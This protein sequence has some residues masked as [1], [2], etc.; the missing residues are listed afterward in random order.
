MD[1][2]LVNTARFKK[3][4]LQELFG[5][6]CEEWQLT[7]N[8]IDDY[9]IDRDKRRCVGRLSATAVHS[10][11]TEDDLL[12]CLRRI[13]ECS[14]E[15]VL[16]SSRGKS[17][18]G[19][20]AARDT[21]RTSGLSAVFPDETIY[22]CEDYSTKVRLVAQLCDGYVEDRTDVVAMLGST[23]VLPFFYDPFD[24]IK[25]HAEPSLAKAHKVRS[26]TNVLD[27]LNSTYQ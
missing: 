22:F 1:G 17:T 6:Y 18:E 7:A 14:K 20:R 23:S 4:K 16:V 11:L 10:C 2:V 8:V 27:Y 5:I 26:I 19:I 9:V 15:M 12:A 21:I 13:R 3:L 24:L 25:A